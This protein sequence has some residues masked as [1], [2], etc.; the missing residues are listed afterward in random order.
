MMSAIFW[1]VTLC[2]FVS[3]SLQSASVPSYTASV[4]PTSSILVT[5]EIEALGSSETSLLKKATRRNIPEDG[6]LQ[7]IIA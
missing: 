7:V 5:L 3:I 6:I 1:D 2:G 4:V